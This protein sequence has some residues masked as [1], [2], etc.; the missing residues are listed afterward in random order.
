[1]RSTLLFLL[2]LMPFS[3]SA[4]SL[5]V[6]PI[7]PIEQGGV[8]QVR[9]TEIPKGVTVRSIDFDGNVTPWYIVGTSVRALRGLPLAAKTGERLLKVSLS[10]GESLQT[11]IIVHPKEKPIL[12]MPSIPKSLGGNTAKSEVALVSS[13]AEENKRIT[14][15]FSQKKALWSVP[16]RPPVTSPFVTDVFGYSRQGTAATITHK[17]TDYRAPVGTPVYAM[18]RGVVRLKRLFRNYGNTVIIDH[19][20]GV[21]TYYMHL[22]RTR[23]TEGQLV[24]PGQ[25]IGFSGDT[26]YVSGAHLHL[27][28]R[29]NGAS[30]DP[31]KFL[32]VMGE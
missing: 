3:V 19:G 28:V 25:L 14:N 12:S 4:T 23:V 13:L 10:N 20:L 16:F 11:I 8:F 17:G 2:V 22:S 18:N 5:W 1:M 30:V 26:G 6:L 15:L 21:M 32:E 24:V 9:V 27:T 31:E 29:I 7:E